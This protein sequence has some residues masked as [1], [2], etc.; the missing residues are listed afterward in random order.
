MPKELFDQTTKITLSAND[1]VAV[2]IPGQEGCDNVF[3][4]NFFKYALRAA[5]DVSVT[6]GAN[7]ISFSSDFGTTDYSLNIYDLNGL[8]IEV[9]AKNTDGFEINSLTSGNINYI[10]IKNI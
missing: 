7:I 4:N 6:V 9:T 1:R 3:V 2:G 5:G 10:A 8:G